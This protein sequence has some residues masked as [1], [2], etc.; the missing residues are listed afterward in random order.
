MDTEKTLALSNGTCKN[1]KHSVSVTVDSDSR[2]EGHL[3]CPAYQFHI[4]S[5]MLAK[6]S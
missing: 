2:R 6:L 3:L 1:Q 4:N 5:L